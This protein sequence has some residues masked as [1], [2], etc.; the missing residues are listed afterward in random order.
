MDS[1]DI[2]TGELMVVN[3]CDCTTVLTII[4][5]TRCFYTYHN[6]IQVQRS[7]SFP[8]LLK[9]IC[10]CVHMPAVTYM[11]NSVYC[12]SWYVLCTLCKIG[13]CIALHTCVIA[14]ILFLKYINFTVYVTLQNWE[15]TI[16]QG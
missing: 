6:Y 9:V 10:V 16:S 5:Y 11:L 15:I 14:C 13:V 3:F 8:S 2:S 12:V 4:I 1:T 7:W